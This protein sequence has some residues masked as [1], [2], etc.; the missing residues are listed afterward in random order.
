MT[1][2]TFPQDFL[3]GSATS[4]YQIEGGWQADGK[5]E[6]IWDRFTHT[7]DRV[8]DGHTGDVACNHYTHWQQDV[9]LMQELKMQAYRFSISWPRILPQGRGAVN[10]KGLDF[11]DRLVD[12]LLANDIQPWATLYHWDL[13]QTLQD[14]GGWPWRGI[15]DAYVNYADVVTNAL[16]DRVKN[17]MTFNEPWV[18]TYMGYASGEHAPGHTSWDEYIQ[19]VHHFLLAHGRSFD[20]IK[21]NVG[22]EANVGAVFNLAWI[23]PA[24]DSEA[25]KAAAQRAM[26][27]H[28]DWFLEPI[29]K[30]TYPQWLVDLYGDD[31]NLEM[32]DGD[33]DAIKGAPDF[34]G[35]NFYFR[36]I[37][38]HD[39]ES[40]SKLQVSLVEPPGE[41]TAMGWEIS[42]PSI[43]NVLKWT[44]EHY[45]PGTIY[46][47]ENGAAFDD[48][49]AGDAVHDERRVAFYKA[50]IANCH[51]AIQ[52]GVPL[53]G[54]FAWSLLDN[55]EW[56][57]GY[58]KRF[59][60]TYV[61]YDTQQRI[62][63]DSGKWYSQVIANNGF[64]AE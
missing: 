6:S 30:G 44:H 4:S 58:G 46:I 23:D 28:N 22:D 40:E 1:E 11:Y 15:V 38:K 33:M 53:K 51:R 31:L 35:L 32:E 25:D 2:L 19:A 7:P 14:R 5:G 41:R 8:V 56:A 37:V 47:T 64:E 55:F 17:W 39:P 50:Y 3:W 45:D 52:D 16:G 43:Y 21:A 18:F 59:G 29:Y 57:L 10:Q 48:V 36:N 62:L 49:P 34:L 12:E 13:P 24:T 63:K 42:P 9:A 54:Y 61:D 60:I 20:V 27:N 26:L